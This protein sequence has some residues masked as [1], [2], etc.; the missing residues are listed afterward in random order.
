MSRVEQL[1]PDQ[2]A[3]LSLLVR[4]GRTYAEVAALLSIDESAVRDRAQRAIIG[5]AGAAPSELDPDDVG[6]IGDYLLGQLAEADRIQ[7]LVVLMDSI[8][9]RVWARAIGAQLEPVASVALPAVPDD[10]DTAPAS[11]PAGPE[12]V[13]A[14]PAL[15]K[16]PERIEAARRALSEPDEPEPG[17][18]GQRAPREPRR[19]ADRGGGVLLVAAVLV[20]AAIVVF[21]TDTGAGSTPARGPIPASAATTAAATTTTSSSG[22]IAEVK[23]TPTTPR[24]NATGAVAVVKNG[25]TLEITFS[26]SKLPA[27]GSAHYILWLYDSS[28]HFEALGDVPAVKANGSVGPLAIAAPSDASSYHGVALTLD[29][30]NSPTSPGQVVL[31]GTSS[32]TL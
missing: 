5:L 2:Q 29:K 8:A 32:S 17:A 25:S 26:A 9:A 15:E 28:T 19:E 16:P 24:S 11:A 23:M 21:I 12:P 13:R 22:I 20:I 6:R 3:V 31:S 30:S 4:Q 18:S 10:P 1:P 27:P 7:T 14:E